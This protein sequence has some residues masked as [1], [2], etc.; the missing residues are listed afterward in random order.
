MKFYKVIWLNNYDVKNKVFPCFFLIPDNWDDY[1]YFTLFKLYLCENESLIK[2]I[3]ELKIINQKTTKKGI[4]TEIPDEFYK[5]SKDFRSLGQSFNYYNNLL[6]NVGK[7]KY[8]DILKSLKDLTLIS[9]NQYDFIKHPA[10]HQSI[11]RFSEAEKKPT[12][13]Q[14]SLLGLWLN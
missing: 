3:G 7:K 9:E 13:N 2:E 8:F 5:L 14:K 6:L 11:V 1:R 10:F 4:L 12:L